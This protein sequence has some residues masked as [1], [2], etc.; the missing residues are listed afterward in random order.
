MENL[1]F[2]KIYIFGEYYMAMSETLKALDDVKLNFSPEGLQLLNIIIGI[3]MFGV[4]LE[5]KGKNFVE[6]ITNPKPVIIGILMQFLILPALTFGLILLFNPTVTVAMGMILIAACPSGNLSNFFSSL[7]KSNVELSVT[8]IGISD[9]MS[10]IMTPFIFGFWAT[11]YSSTSYS[12]AQLQ[13][14]PFDMLQIVVISLGIPTIAGMIIGAKLPKFTSKIIKPIKSISLIILLI[15]IIVALSQNFSNFLK[16]I[17]LVFFIVLAH[18]ALALL[19]GFLISKLF[20]LSASDTRTITIVTGIRN[21]GLGLM[22]I[23]TPSLFNGIG[24][25]ALIAAWW[26]IWHIIT[27]LGLGFFWGAR[28]IK[29]DLN[30]I[31]S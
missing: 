8:M 1:F 26:G 18:N 7:A 14:N 9:L 6:V 17:H 21:S 3:I 31:K 28:P 2:L 20:F 4:A 11:L 15:Y 10:L 25:M 29:T 22:I 27:G 12:Y 30:E 5:L 16:C 23:F 13:I 24:G 19:A